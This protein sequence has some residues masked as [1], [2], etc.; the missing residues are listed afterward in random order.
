[1]THRNLLKTRM[2]IY[3]VACVNLTVD[4]PL[5]MRF[6]GIGEGWKRTWFL[7]ACSLAAIVCL[8]AALRE[9]SRLKTSN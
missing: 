7:A 9:L 3:F 5:M 2:I 1:M 6:V 8:W 4:G